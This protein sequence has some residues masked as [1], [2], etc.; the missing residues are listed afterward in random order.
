MSPASD[1]WMEVRGKIDDLEAQLR[2]G[3]HTVPTYLAATLFFLASGFFTG[4][5]A[6]A[7]VLAVLCVAAAWITHRVRRTRVEQL[8]A[9]EELERSLPGERHDGMEAP[10]PEERGRGG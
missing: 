3:R 7:L 10:G 1:R 5:W 9:L 6:P 4:A 2:Q 8:R